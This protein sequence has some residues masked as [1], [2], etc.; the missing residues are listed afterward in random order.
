MIPKNTAVA[1]QKTERKI[2]RLLRG[3]VF[4][5]QEG[6]CNICQQEVDNH[7]GEPHNQRTQPNSATLDHI[8]P[9]SKGGSK[10]DRDNLQILCIPCHSKK[11]KE[12]FPI[13]AKQGKG[14]RRIRERLIKEQ[15]HR[16]T[17]CKKG[18]SNHGG[19]YLS[20][21][22]S[23]SAIVDDIDLHIQDEQSIKEQENL[24]VI[25]FACYMKKWRNTNDIAPQD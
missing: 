23:N 10:L 5:E 16:C 20:R 6:K 24:Q 1:R 4:M 13:K 12:E 2:I 9:I 11:T 25:C 8:L 3:L 7:S 22:Q 14:T 19:G 15:N 21:L 17:Q 18:I